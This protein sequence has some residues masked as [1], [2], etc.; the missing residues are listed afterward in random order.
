M[1]GHVAR[2]EMDLRRAV[3]VA[4]DETK[5][6]FGEEASFLRPEATHN[7]EI[8]RDQP[9]AVVDEQIAGVH[10]GMK[11]AVAQCVAQE[12]LNHLA[13]KLRQ[14]EAFCLQRAVITEPECLD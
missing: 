5:Q 13:S 3:V 8:D 9:P 6:N 2:I 11:E 4:R 12:A 14:I 1:P 10:V 7:A